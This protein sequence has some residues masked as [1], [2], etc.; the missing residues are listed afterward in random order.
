LPAAYNN[1]I[2][3]MVGVPYLTLGTLLFLVYRGCKKNELFKNQMKAGEP[4]GS[5]APFAG[6]EKPD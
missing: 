5:P 3:L 6:D 4:G 1:S 2:Y